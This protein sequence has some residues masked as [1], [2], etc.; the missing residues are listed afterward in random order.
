MPKISII[1][2]V[3]NVQ[4]YIARCLDSIVAQTYPDFEVIAVNDA[5]SDKSI[6]IVYDYARHDER[7]KVIEKEHSGLGLSRNAGLKAA[8]GEYVMFVDSDDFLS[9]NALETLILK[10]QKYGS[11][12]VFFNM[13]SENASKQSTEIC[14]LPYLTDSDDGS[15]SETVYKDLFGRS[16]TGGFKDVPVLGSV[17]RRFIKRSLIFENN[18]EFKNEEDILLEDNLFSIYLH[19]KA[20]RP[21]FITDALYHYRC[22]GGTLSTSFRPGKFEKLKSYYS[23][24]SEFIKQNDLPDEYQSRLGA[25]FLR[26]A[27]HESAVNCFSPTNKISPAKKYRQI[28]DILSDER[29]HNKAA[30]DYFAN[31]SKKDRIITRLIAKFPPFAV[32]AFYRLYTLKSLI[33]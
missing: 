32:F 24:V 10:A 8:K 12:L 5:S 4:K 23:S 7:I 26:F 11:D 2:P 29:L 25:W 27:A 21:L 17:C 3:Y 19:S 22:N 28:K 6:D 9:L 13:I 16:T 14:Y 20:A 15:L 31:A 1:L 18:F 30:L 33:G